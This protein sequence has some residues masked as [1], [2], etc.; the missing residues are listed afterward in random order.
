MEISSLGPASVSG[1]IPLLTLGS[2]LPLRTRYFVPASIWH[3]AKLHLGLL[4]Y[5][6]DRYTL[7]G[8]TL[9]D[10]MA[11]S[12]SLLLAALSARHVIARDVEARWV[13]LMRE[14]AARI[15]Q[16]AGLF[17]GT[18]SVARADARLPWEI[19]CDHVICSPPYGCE[20]SGTTRAK[21]GL[22]Y[23]LARHRHD[24]RWE[25]YLAAPTNGTAGMLSFHYG[26]TPGQ[27]GKRR[28]KGYWR[29]MEAVYRQAFAAIRPHGR[30]ILIVKDHIRDGQRVPTADMTIDLCQSIG[31]RLTERFQRRVYPLSLWQ[32]RRKE[33][34]LPVVEE[35]DVL[36]LAR[37]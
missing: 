11:G 20:M 2:D 16:D 36:V 22:A 24:Q 23:R 34:G 28:G 7:P 18:I 4:Q 8:E 6:I 17:A 33:A 9:C 25:R 30:L 19:T 35:E 13:A 10:P 31:F 32:R 12:G 29:A 1:A 37:P 26:N 14:N 21:K 5:L 15:Q 3:P 27:L